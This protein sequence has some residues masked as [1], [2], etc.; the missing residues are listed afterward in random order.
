VIG[1]VKNDSITIAQQYYPD[2]SI[3]QGYGYIKAINTLDDHY[4]KHAVVSMHYAVTNPAGQIN[5]FGF[6]DDGEA[7]VWTK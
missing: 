7:S 4:Y 1:L 3:I 5:K 6:P 2:G